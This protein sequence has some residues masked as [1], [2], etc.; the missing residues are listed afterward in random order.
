[1]RSSIERFDP[2]PLDLPIWI[3]PTD[4]HL[5][6]LAEIIGTTRVS[7]LL[8]FFQ[9]RVLRGEESDLRIS[10][11]TDTIEVAV[12]LE[13]ND[14]FLSLPLNVRCTYARAPVTTRGTSLAVVAR[15]GE[16]HATDGIVNGTELT[17]GFGG[18]DR[19]LMHEDR[20]RLATLYLWLSQ[21]FPDVYASGAAIARV[22]E[23]I[24]DDIHDALLRQG[25]R[26]KRERPAP[27][28]FR[29]K[30]PPKFNPRR[31]RK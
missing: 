2:A 14:R 23:Q 13:M 27:K 18:V 3:S 4:E 7:R 17:N 10:N 28:P 1:L 12:A 8:Q 20:S 9:T 5:R 30:G 24:D 21:R 29:R 22:R 6:R 15:W 31:L 16:L 25:D 11:L 19:L 26:P